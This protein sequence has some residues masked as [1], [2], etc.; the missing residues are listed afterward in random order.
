[1]GFFDDLKEGFSND[2]RLDN[3]KIKR[4]V[5][6]GVNKNAPSYV[7]KKEQERQQREKN[8]ATAQ[9][10]NKGSEPQGDRTLKDLFSGWTWE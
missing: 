8:R 3:A 1:M 5:N 4:D 2:P 9:K 10:G 6:A 7:K